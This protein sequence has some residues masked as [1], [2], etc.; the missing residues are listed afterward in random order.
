MSVVM[1]RVTPQRKISVAEYYKLAE[2]GLLAS[3]ARVELIEGEIVDMPRMGSLHTGVAAYVSQQL[4]LALAERATVFTQCT[5]SLNEWSAPEPDVYVCQYR[6][7][8]YEGKLPTPREVYLVIEVSHSTLSTD[9]S[10]KASLYAR[11][12]V[13]EYWI[14]DVKARRLE[15]HR[16]ASEG[17]YREVTTVLEPVPVSIQLL[18]EIKIDLSRYFRR[19]D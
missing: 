3:D 1:D 9:R 16:D 4:I 2:E 7:D 19:G 12:G 11:A 14:F 15:M 13:P 18:P 6:S 17:K 5:I 10:I 8:F